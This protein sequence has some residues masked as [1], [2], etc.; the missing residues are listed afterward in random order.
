M[1]RLSQPELSVPARP[2]DV[3][4]KVPMMEPNLVRWNGAAGTSEMVQM[5]AKL[6]S[7]GILRVVTRPHASKACSFG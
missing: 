6:R 4:D 2:N 3:C 7:C 1:L 5:M